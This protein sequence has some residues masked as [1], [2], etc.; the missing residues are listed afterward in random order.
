[1]LIMNMRAQI[2]YGR[3]LNNIRAPHGEKS[4]EREQSPSAEPQDT[5]ESSGDIVRGQGR[6]P[7]DLAEAHI[8]ALRDNFRIPRAPGPQAEA[9]PPQASL[10]AEPQAAP[11]S[12][13]HRDSS[14]VANKNGTLSLLQERAPSAPQGEEKGINFAARY[15][16]TSTAPGSSRTAFA[17]GFVND[18]MDARQIDDRVLKL[19][20][21][22]PDLVKVTTREYG[23]AG[24]DG[25]NASLRGPAP[26]RYVT[27]SS[28]KGDKAS[29]PGALFMASPHGREKMNPLAM[30]E[31]L[32][33]LCANYRPGSDDP[34][35]R[36]L[37]D[38]VDS[39]NIYVVPVTNPDGLNYAIHDDPEWRRTRAPLAGSGS[40]DKG[41]D[42]NRNFDIE[43]TPYPQG[44]SP[45]QQKIIREKGMLPHPTDNN[46]LL[47]RWTQH[48][49]YPG[50]APFSEPETR[51]IA[52]IVDEH[53]E[54]RVACDFHSHGEKVMIPDSVT[55]A[56]DREI[57]ENLQKRMIGAVG[58]PQ[59]E[60][61]RP[62]LSYNV[63]GQTD[64]YLYRRKGIY[65][66]TMEDGKE[67]NPPVPE[68]LK[69]ADSMASGAIELLR[70][71][72]E[73]GKKP[74][75]MLPPKAHGYDES[76]PCPAGD[77]AA[78]HKGAPEEA[79]KKLDTRAHPEVRETFDRY[80]REHQQDL[81][82]LTPEKYEALSGA[83]DGKDGKP[84][85]NCIAN[86]VRNEKEIIEPKVFVERFDEFY[87]AH[88][89]KPL[90][91]LDYSL[92]EGIEKVVLYGFT[93]SDGKD[94][95]IRRGAWGPD[96]ANYQGPLC[97]HAVIQDEDGLFSSKM[98]IHER[99]RIADPGDLGGGLYGNPVRV[100]A[101][102]RR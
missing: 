39:L 46:K 91:T 62:E 57:F 41:V 19:A 81:P 36:E 101:R 15:G 98:G 64:D 85:F 76:R 93:P 5:M 31:L 56:H 22:Y 86:S 14:L 45:E 95:E 73:L 29:K 70:A 2:G 51:H 10:Q 40:G 20:E 66:L 67:F 4:S 9:A 33:Q 99:I 1:M 23:T 74:D 96:Y 37:T 59:G 17:R 13:Q 38:L 65:A 77:A 34:K 63:N 102:P 69:V 94:Y 97:Y 44:A 50:P 49:G 11:S 18:Y 43:W 68:A 82:R 25:K 87:G 75:I 42:I 52:G 27:I 61:Y 88:G 35:V 26:L 84:R 83:T 12:D 72:K 92:R 47:G 30:V 24:Y 7:A 28:G 90:D 80:L 89:F 79:G 100:Y 78:D 8:D 58:K 53:P 54:I 6:A 71:A 3:E 16:V 55:D 32:E 21:K 60:S 48:D